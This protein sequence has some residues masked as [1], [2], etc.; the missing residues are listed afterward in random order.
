M[1]DT[2]P[3]LTDDEQVA[4]LRALCRGYARAPAEFE[5]EQAM[6]WIDHMR[7]DILSAEGVLHGWYSMR[8]QDGRPIFSQR[9]Q[10]RGHDHPG[11]GLSC[12]L[13]LNGLSAQDWL[14]STSPWP[15]VEIHE[16]GLA[17]DSVS[18][19]LTDRLLRAES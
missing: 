18:P 9:P 12:A 1:G 13:P 5:I 16:W 4:L 14:D 6:L 10:F 15:K 8:M 11:G 2:F 19:E 3:Y 7:S 17:E